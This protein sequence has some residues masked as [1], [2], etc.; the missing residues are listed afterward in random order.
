MDSNKP[1]VN[2]ESSIDKHE[3]SEYI[4]PRAID[5][6]CDTRFFREALFCLYKKFDGSS[7]FFRHYA[8]YAKVS[9]LL[10]ELGYR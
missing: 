4:T 1:S 8:S 5:S 7:F 9:E 10:A 3:Y 6:V 2:S